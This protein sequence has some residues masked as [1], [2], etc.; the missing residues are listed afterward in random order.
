[1]GE[2]VFLA[3]NSTEISRLE[4]ELKRRYNA[5]SNG[6]QV[7]TAPLEEMLEE[8]RAKVERGNGER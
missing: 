2:L 6:A 3:E 7:L 4:N 1:M 8:L 5:C